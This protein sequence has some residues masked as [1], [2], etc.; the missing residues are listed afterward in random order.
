MVFMPTMAI[1][2]ASSAISDAITAENGENS[3]LKPLKTS[4]YTAPATL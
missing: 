2:S 4:I 3:G 1:S